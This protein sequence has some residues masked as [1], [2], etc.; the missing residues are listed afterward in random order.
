MLAPRDTPT[1]ERKSLDGLWRFLPD[2]DGVG[3]EQRWFDELGAGAR[4]RVRRS[5]P[6]AAVG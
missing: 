3:N 2:P 1:R 6:S 5:R 4:I